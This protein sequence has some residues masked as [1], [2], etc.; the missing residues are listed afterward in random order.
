[1][2][3]VQLGIYSEV[4][5][6]KYIKVT[7]DSLA[8]KCSINPPVTYRIGSEPL[9]I[10]VLY[11]NSSSMQNTPGI[12]VEPLLFDSG[13]NELALSQTSWISYQQVSESFAVSTVGDL[14]PG[15]FQLGL[16]LSY[17]GFPLTATKCMK[18]VI[19]QQA[20]TPPAN[21]TEVI[22]EVINKTQPVA[23]FTS[24]KMTSYFKPPN[25][26]TPDLPL[27]V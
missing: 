3:V 4:K 17:D 9:P 8:L 7:L 6:T 27:R 12:L 10:E 20:S 15:F 22:P 21:V 13:N 2:L 14:D 1:M 23:N 11:T 19:M 16:S 18:T 24:P 26:T 5:L 25:T